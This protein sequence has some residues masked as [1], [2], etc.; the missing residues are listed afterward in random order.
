MEGR[1]V[2]Q[3]SNEELAD[4]LERIKRFFARSD[5]YA[6]SETVAVCEEAAR[7]LRGQ[8][9]TTLDEHAASDEWWTARASYQ[10]R[11]TVS[12]DLPC[13]DD[14]RVVI[15]AL[16]MRM[17]EYERRHMRA[18]AAAL[19]SML[20][21]VEIGGERV[22]QALRGTPTPRV[23]IER[24]LVPL[25]TLRLRPK[26]LEHL[27]AAIGDELRRFHKI[28]C[29]PEAAPSEI[30]EVVDEIINTTREHVEMSS[31]AESL[32]DSVVEGALRAQRGAG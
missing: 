6:P 16:R 7:R 17:A 8:G 5:R 24:V 9:G 32:P 12:V 27:R 10:S 30:V 22:E 15:E 26:I 2:R 31:T 20:R 23:E 13:T 11:A 3:L 14:P 25:S 4:K 1:D 29:Y 21:F 19:S 28:S 18:E